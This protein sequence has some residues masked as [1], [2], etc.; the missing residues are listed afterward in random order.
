MPANNIEWGA[1]GHALWRADLSS[2]VFLGLLN[3]YSCC[4]DGVHVTLPFD[5][6]SDLVVR[7]GTHY[8]MPMI[9]TIPR[10]SFTCHEYISIDPDGGVWTCGLDATIPGY[11]IAKWNGA[12]WD[13]IVVVDGSGGPPPDSTIPGYIN[14]EKP[15]EILW[16][17][18]PFHTA[19]N[20]NTRVMST[21]ISSGVTS[22]IWDC[23]DPLTNPFPDGSDSGAGHEFAFQ[24]FAVVWLASTGDYWI[25]GD[26][27]KRTA[28]LGVGSGSWSTADYTGIVRVE[29]D[30][31]TVTQEGGEAAVHF[32]LVHNDADRVWASFYNPTSEHYQYVW[33][34]TDVAVGGGYAPGFDVDRFQMFRPGDPTEAANQGIFFRGHHGGGVVGVHAVGIG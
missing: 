17:G 29:S 8:P 20:N 26:H 34:D 32:M 18:G 10:P 30:L 11:V 22:V 13:Q 12:S 15:G 2:G 9:G 3:G 31:A 16:C 6:T 27:Q 5:G 23:K 24:P 19:T 21:D 7:D 28:I 1:S 25:C 14:A 4:R 33:F